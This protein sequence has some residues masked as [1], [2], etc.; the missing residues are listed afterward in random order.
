MATYTAKDIEVLEGLEPVGGDGRSLCFDS[1]AALARIYAES[2]PAERGGVAGSA[3]LPAQIAK[4]TA[5]LEEL[6][7]R[8]PLV[9]EARRPLLERLDGSA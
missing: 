5:L 1:R 2:S 3:L 7:R 8:L 4:L 9:G 6:A